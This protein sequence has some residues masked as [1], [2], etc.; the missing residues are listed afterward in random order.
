MVTYSVTTNWLAA[1]DTVTQPRTLND[2]TQTSLSSQL[3]EEESWDFGVVK[4]PLVW[5]ESIAIPTDHTSEVSN[6]TF[7]KD[8]LV[9]NKLLLLGRTKEGRWEHLV[10]YIASDVPYEVKWN[11]YSEMSQIVI[12]VN[13]ALQ[14][15]AKFFYNRQRRCFIQT[16][17]THHI[18]QHD[19][20]TTSKHLTQTHE[21][22]SD[23]VKTSRREVSFKGPSHMDDG[24]T[25]LT[26]T[27]ISSPLPIDGSTPARSSLYPAASISA[28]RKH[29]PCKSADKMPTALLDLSSFIVIAWFTR[30]E[31]TSLQGEGFKD[32]DLHETH[33]QPESLDEETP[34]LS[35]GLEA[36]YGI[37]HKIL[38][39][40]AQA[41]SLTEQVLQVLKGSSHRR[42]WDRVLVNHDSTPRQSL[43]SCSS[44]T[45]IL[46]TY[47][48]PRQGPTVS[49][50]CFMGK[51]RIRKECYD[52][53]L[54]GFMKTAACLRDQAHKSY[55]TLEGLTAPCSQKL[56]CDWLERIGE[57][58]QTLR[59]ARDRTRMKRCSHLSI[60]LRIYSE[61][62]TKYNRTMVQVEMTSL[63][64]LER[65][66]LM[67][68]LMSKRERS[69]VSKNPSTATTG[70]N[71]ARDLTANK[72]QGIRTV[73]I[74]ESP[75][76][77]MISIFTSRKHAVQR[78]PGT[79]GIDSLV[80]W[81]PLDKLTIMKYGRSL[82]S[83]TDSCRNPVESG[84]F[85]EF[86]RNQIWQ[87]GLPN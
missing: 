23:L 52:Q 75:T 22:E 13:R 86:Q 10:R 84:Q 4:G 34:S 33:P 77:Y 12:L 27:V 14:A 50:K 56:H 81:N 31:S 37:E 79:R 7:D 28:N 82:L 67:P 1:S 17:M 73:T 8:V 57:E 58:T 26:D 74:E 71:L 16:Q 19:T 65:Q 38:S 54:E 18:L 87:R 20:T 49:F 29:A 63:G 3:E 61:T 46:S 30:G 32:E 83:S 15:P 55:W 70:L 76:P 80:T 24:P 62:P 9:L 47:R 5:I 45:E 39:K 21:S 72:D 43:T 11:Q 6:P 78:S 42:K 48:L 25:P 69:I 68:H 2:K 40:A 85:P 35:T 41:I 59:H 60:T 53:I 64:V 66:P 44:Q 51:L 36:S